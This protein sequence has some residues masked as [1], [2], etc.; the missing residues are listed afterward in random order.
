MPALPRPPE[1]VR[2]LWSTRESMW[3]ASRSDWAAYG[4]K[5]GHTTRFHTVDMSRITGLAFFYGEGHK[6]LQGIHAHTEAA[7]FS[8]IPPESY[9]WW[10]EQVWVYVP[11]S[12]TDKV[13]ALAAMTRGESYRVGG[14]LV[15]PRLDGA[16]R[17]LS[18]S[19]P[20][21]S[22]LF[23]TRGTGF[24]SA[25]GSAVS[26]PWGPS[27]RQVVTTAEHTSSPRPPRP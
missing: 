15:R 7:P 8:A 21:P 11:V 18:S 16:T 17:L 3:S 20:H 1:T 6:I 4:D 19:L 12:A 13:T 9:L 5:P 23:L 27:A 2:S 22:Y 10:L 14:L 25:P 26:S 24:R